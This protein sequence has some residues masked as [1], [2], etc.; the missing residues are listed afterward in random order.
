MSFRDN[1]DTRRQSGSFRD[2]PDTGRQGSFRDHPDRHQ[3]HVQEYDVSQ[4][5][6][7]GDSRSIVPQVPQLI[8]QFSA[9]LPHSGATNPRSL[10]G[11]AY[12]ETRGRTSSDHSRHIE[13]VG[14]SLIDGP[15]DRPLIWSSGHAIESVRTTTSSNTRQAFGVTSALSYTNTVQRSTSASLENSGVSDERS[16]DSL[17]SQSTHHSA[18]SELLSSQPSSENLPSQLRDSLARAAYRPQYHS[19]SGSAGESFHNTPPIE[20]RSTIP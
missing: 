2:N 9:Q 6:S 7:S 1:P 20:D 5:N 17:A 3:K 18:H 13:N 12:Y 15:D 4:K 11:A 14:S 19:G 10:Q 8:N 16:Y